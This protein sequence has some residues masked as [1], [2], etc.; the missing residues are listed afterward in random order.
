MTVKPRRKAGKKRAKLKEPE[1]ALKKHGLRQRLR[2]LMLRRSK[3]EEG[4]SVS[5]P[6]TARPTSDER[7][8]TGS[9]DLDR[10]LKGGIPKRHATLA[11][12]PPGSGKTTLCFQF[13]WEGLEHGERCL[14][15]SLEE[16]KEAILRTAENYGWNFRRYMRERRLGIIIMDP[17]DIKGTTEVLRNKF[18]KIMKWWGFDRVVIDP[19][20]LFELIFVDP[21]EKRQR[22]FELTD[23]IKRS[24]ATAMYTAEVK[25]DNPI[26]THSGLIEYAC[27]A[28]I[29]LR[30]M[31]TP[32]GELKFSI[33]PIKVRRSDHSK[34]MVE[35][36]I[37]NQGITIHP[38]RRL[39]TQGHLRRKSK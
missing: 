2:E 17:R 21:A 24:G 30:Y 7:V 13:L 33:Q 31:V 36:E 38:T 23:L 35:F 26:S 4:A 16:N 15:V 34:D 20:S 8:S 9:R 6:T 11:I 37:T 27:D 1:K 3:S 10:M 39:D 28:F 18:P 32:E 19:L 22:V 5:C 12:G 29:S 14:L 25:P